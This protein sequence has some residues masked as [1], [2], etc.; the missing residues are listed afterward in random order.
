VRFESREIN[1]FNVTRIGYWFVV[2][3]RRSNEV[4]G[5]C[6]T[7]IGAATL[8]EFLKKDLEN[9]KKTNQEK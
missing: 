9:E 7:M 4:H 3:D 5:H 6:T 2:F 1:I 8:V